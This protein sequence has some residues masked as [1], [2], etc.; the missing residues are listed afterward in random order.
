MVNIFFYSAG[1]YERSLEITYEI[2][3]RILIFVDLIYLCTK[4]CTKMYECR[5][6]DF[7]FTIH[8]TK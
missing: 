8:M 6:N 1:D 4:I 7:T 2:I 5:Q 3:C